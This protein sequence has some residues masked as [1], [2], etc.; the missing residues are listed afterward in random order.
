MASP[1]ILREMKFKPATEGRMG[2]GLTIVCVILGVGTGSLSGLR[3]ASAQC[4][5]NL[6][7]NASHD[8]I[9]S[10]YMKS[11]SC[12]YVQN[13]ICD[14]NE[15]EAGYCRTETCAQCGISGNA[16][17][18]ICCQTDEACEVSSPVLCTTTC[19]D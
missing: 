4:N 2:W 13:C 5:P 14:N 3:V 6:M 16:T 9:P 8:G 10:D 15:P 11:W 17:A 18:S 12:S 19:C 7:C 1:K